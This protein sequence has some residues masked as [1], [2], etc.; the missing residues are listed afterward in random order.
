MEQKPAEQQKHLPGPLSACHL[1]VPSLI[2]VSVQGK[3]R[4]FYHLT[5]Q[6]HD[7]AEQT[8]EDFCVLFRLKTALNLLSDI[9]VIK[10]QR[11]P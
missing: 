9:S 5:A 10:A 2:P 3:I 7:Q 6:P 8:A 1:H 4:T 11:T